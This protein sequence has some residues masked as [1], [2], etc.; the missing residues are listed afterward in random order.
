MDKQGIA[1]ISGSQ[2]PFAWRC[3]LQLVPLSSRHLQQPG[4]VTLPFSMDLRDLSS[5]AAAGEARPPRTAA[6]GCAHPAPR[7]RE[8]L[9][10]SST[11]LTSSRHLALVASASLC[12]LQCGTSSLRTG[13]IC[14]ASSCLGEP[15]PEGPPAALVAASAFA[16]VN[17]KLLKPPLRARVRAAPCCQAPARAA[18]GARGQRLSQSARAAVTRYH[19]PCG[20]WTTGIYCHSL[21]WRLKA[22]VRCSR[23]VSAE[24]SLRLSMA[25]SQQRP[26]KEET[27]SC[28]RSLFSSG[29]NPNARGPCPV[30]SHGPPKRRLAETR[31]STYGSG[32]RYTPEGGFSC[33]C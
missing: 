33:V 30:S 21:L 12:G 24:A 7:P 8:R 13:S 9:L 19:W 11:R 26:R 14:P 28:C 1:Q 27:T 3:L 2:L 16:G 18:T 15:P 25:G 32:Y 4:G 31:A 20:V 23:A 5:T 17:L 29:T 10:S 22:K 6:Q